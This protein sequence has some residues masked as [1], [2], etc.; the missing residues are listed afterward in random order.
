MMP[1]P[2]R[3]EEEAN[4]VRNC[5]R[6]R[7]VVRR[8][9]VFIQHRLALHLSINDALAIGDSVDIGCLFGGIET[10]HFEL[11]CEH[12]TTLLQG[13]RDVQPSLLT[14]KTMRRG[15]NRIPLIRDDLRHAQRSCFEIGNMLGVLSSRGLTRG[16]LEGF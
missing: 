16:W 10:I 12:A 1:V 6:S 8:S 3:D 15:L 4:V 9:V 5:T 7:S 11:P 14:L 13:N 2:S